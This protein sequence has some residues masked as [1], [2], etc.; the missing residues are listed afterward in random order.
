MRENKS[1]QTR[2][3]I[4]MTLHCVFETARAGPPFEFEPF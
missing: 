2:L 1:E 3:C 4:L